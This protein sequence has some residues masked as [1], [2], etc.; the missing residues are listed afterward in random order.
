MLMLIAA[1]G[2]IIAT[3]CDKKKI[4]DLEKERDQAN[5]DKDAIS[6]TLNGAH[7]KFV[8]DHGISGRDSAVFTEADFWV[9][10]NESGTP[11]NTSTGFDLGPVAGSISSRSP[12]EATF[13]VMK[14]PK[15]THYIYGHSH[16]MLDT[17][18]T[19]VEVEVVGGKNFEIL[20]DHEC[21]S[22][23]VHGYIK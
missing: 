5:S 4:E 6:Q 7:G 12:E 11:A 15:G 9:W 17:T 19:A 3:S 20:N 23:H 14:M 1:C 21:P 22:L 13:T 18:G 16:V 8:L 10:F 2:L